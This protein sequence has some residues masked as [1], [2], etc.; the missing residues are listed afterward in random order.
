MY[1]Y[2]YTHTHNYFCIYVLFLAVEYRRA[3][4]HDSTTGAGELSFTDMFDTS[5]SL[6]QDTQLSR[7]FAKGRKLEAESSCTAIDTHD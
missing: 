7:V 1:I 3:W 4:V 6:T 5:V 2:I